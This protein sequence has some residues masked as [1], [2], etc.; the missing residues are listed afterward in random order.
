MSRLYLSGLLFTCLF[1]FSLPPATLAQPGL[2]G[3]ELRQ[4]LDGKQLIGSLLEK[5]LYGGNFKGSIGTVKVVKDENMSLTLS[6]TYSGFEEGYFHVSAAGEGGQTVT[7]VQPVKALIDISK[8]Q[9]EIRLSAYQDRYGDSDSLIA[10]KLVVLVSKNEN[11]SHGI[12]NIYTLDKIFTVRAEDFVIAVNLVPIQAAG[13]LPATLPT[14]TPNPV[15]TKPVRKV[16]MIDKPLYYKNVPLAISTNTRTTGSSAPATSTG[17][18]TSRPVVSHVR[19]MQPVSLHVLA[20]RGAA[21]A[22]NK[23]PQGPDNN[24]ISF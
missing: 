19:L 17:K 9:M 1:L 5:L 16:K 3:K 14:N 22:T 11:G 20:E 6:I 7:G 8:Q 4:D 13:L 21:P 15:F 10:P 12:K 2:E 18:E 23:T 24:P